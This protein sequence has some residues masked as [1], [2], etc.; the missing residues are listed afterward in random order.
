MGL[1]IICK[2]MLT[3]VVLKEPHPNHIAFN[4]PNDHESNQIRKF[5]PK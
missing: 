2:K 5:S 3:K 4:I 1:D